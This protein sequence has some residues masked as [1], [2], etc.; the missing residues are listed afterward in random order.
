MGNGEEGREG[1]RSGGK[2]KGG[3]M[4]EEDVATRDGDRWGN[5]IHSTFTSM[6]GFNFW[7]VCCFNVIHCEYN[8]IQTQVGR[9]NCNKME[10]WSSSK[11]GSTRWTL[12]W[13]R[14]ITRF[15]C[16]TECKSVF[17]FS[18]WLKGGLLFPLLLICYFLIVLLCTCKCDVDENK[19]RLLA[20]PVISQFNNNFHDKGHLSLCH[21]HHFSLSYQHSMLRP[22]WGIVQPHRLISAASECSHFHTHS[23][24]QWPS[25]KHLHL[26][27][28]STDLFKLFL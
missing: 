13:V 10:H 11:R 3:G 22:L 21:L 28:I 15:E 17:V 18:F 24:I 16:W 26:L 5:Y 2:E 8:E 20:E 9:N 4:V 1:A 19:S 14:Q 25:E 6:F 7:S 12:F 23:T 27:Y